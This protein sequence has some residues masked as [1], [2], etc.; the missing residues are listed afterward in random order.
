MQVLDQLQAVV[1]A[2]DAE[3]Y[4]AM[5]QPALKRI[6]ARDAEDWPVLASTTK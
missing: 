1:Q 4:A 6:S 5:R 2:L 3:I